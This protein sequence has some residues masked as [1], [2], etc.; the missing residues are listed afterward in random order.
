MQLPEKLTNQT[1]ENEEKPNF[2]SDFGLL[3]PTLGPQF[4]FVDFTSAS[5]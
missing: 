2:E 1:S 5:S 4:F 3:D